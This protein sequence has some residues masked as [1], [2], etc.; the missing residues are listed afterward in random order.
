ML[1]S[2]RRSSVLVRNHGAHSAATPSART[3]S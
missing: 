1:R 2:I 3:D